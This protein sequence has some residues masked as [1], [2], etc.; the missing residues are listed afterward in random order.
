MF[1]WLTSLPAQRLVRLLKRSHS[2]RRK[3]G[4]QEEADQQKQ[5]FAET[6]GMGIQRGQVRDQLGQ[7]I[8][9]QINQ[10]N[11]SDEC[12]K[13]ES[14]EGERSTPEDNQEYFHRMSLN[15]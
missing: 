10:V 3:L 14:H 4:H 11:H 2:P 7:S 15:V 8:Q 1:S 13:C 6:I 12:A 9:K 5:N